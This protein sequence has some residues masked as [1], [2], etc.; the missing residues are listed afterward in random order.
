MPHDWGSSAAQAA[1]AL[2]PRARGVLQLRGGPGTGKT[3]L[4]EEVAHAHVAAGVDANS[5]LLLTGSG[6]L[7]AADRGA[8]TA[9]LLAAGGPD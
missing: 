5:V 6:R 9:T 3:R 8:L 7:P 1:A 2:D 4:L